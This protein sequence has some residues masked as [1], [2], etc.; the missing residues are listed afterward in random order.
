MAIIVR[1]AVVGDA[2]KLSGL[3]AKTFFETFAHTTTAEN[4]DSYLAD[5]YS[6][7]KQASEIAD[8]DN[9]VFIAESEQGELVGFTYVGS[10]ETLE[11]VSGPNVLEL[12][13]IYVAAAWQGHGVAQSLMNAALNA[14]A[15][16]GAQTIWLGVWENNGRALGFYRKYGFERVGEHT[17]MVG[18]DAQTDWVL[19]RTL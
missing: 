11:C 12:K 18:D 5:A 6:P 15:A 16:R 10:G 4:M 19:A 8:P 13:R 1:P 9:T 2:E 14:A 7:E 3:A 17:F